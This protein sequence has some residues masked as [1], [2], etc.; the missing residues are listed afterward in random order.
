[1]T[2]YL[3]EATCKILVHADSLEAA[4]ESAQAELE[5]LCFDVFTTNVEEW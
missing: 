3:V 4:E 2:A 1:M 5:E